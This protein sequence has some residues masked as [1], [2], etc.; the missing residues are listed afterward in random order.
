LGCHPSHR[1]KFS[2]LQNVCLVHIKG[3][4]DQINNISDLPFPAQLNIEADRLATRFQRSSSH[5]Q[6]QGPIIPGTECHLLIEGQVTASHQRRNLRIRKGQ[7]QILQYTQQRHHLSDV[8]ILDID[9]ES[10]IRAINTFGKIRHKFITK[11]LSIWLPVGKHVHRYNPT[12]H[13][14][15]FPSCECPTEDFNHAFRCPERR[16]WHSAL[17][18]DLIRLSDRTKTNHK[19]TD[20]LLQGIHHRLDDTPTPPQSPSPRYNELLESQTNIGWDQLFF[21]QWSTLWMHHQGI[22]LQQQNINPTIYNHGIGWSSKIISTIWT[23]CYDAWI[24][25]CQAIHG[26]NQ[27]T[28]HLARLDQAQYKT[29]AL[30]GAEPK[31]T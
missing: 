12:A 29:R 26:S 27:Q 20:L 30:Y 16:Q 23:H 28:R 1:K 24:A 5:A 2:L 17:R 15:H 6:E 9:W 4:Q 31:C 13:S 7:N 10:H 19:L 22:Y 21:G 8:A 3:H 11:F 18:Q 14:C 25:R